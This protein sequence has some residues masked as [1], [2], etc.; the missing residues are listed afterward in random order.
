M[1]CSE[2]EQLLAVAASI[3]CDLEQDKS[4]P[5]LPRSDETL[6]LAAA[7]RALRIALFS[8]EIDLAF[9]QTKCLICR[10][11]DGHPDTAA[12]EFLPQNAA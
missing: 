2:R 8:A 9:H 12:K 6:F 7:E 3:Q 1:M 5:S 4:S 11:V 10:A